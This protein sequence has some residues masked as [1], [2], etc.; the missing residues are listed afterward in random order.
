MRQDHFLRSLNVSLPGMAR[1]KPVAIRSERVVPIDT[2]D[3]SPAQMSKKLSLAQKMGLVPMPPAKLSQ[4][5]WK[6]VAEQSR[7]GP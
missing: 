2:K 3:P 5:E 7:S 1:K 4:E 6:K